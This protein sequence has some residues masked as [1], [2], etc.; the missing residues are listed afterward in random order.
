MTQHKEQ[1]SLSYLKKKL[2]PY[3][4]M[5]YQTLGTQN[6]TSGNVLL[7]MKGLNKKRATLCVCVFVLTLY[8]EQNSITKLEGP[9]SYCHKVWSVA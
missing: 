2:L 6:E 1:E 8:P 4:K 5:V 7:A 9:L 3:E